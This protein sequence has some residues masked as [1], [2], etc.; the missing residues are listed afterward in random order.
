MTDSAY[1]M[2]SGAMTRRHRA[3]DDPGFG[4][5]ALAE[6]LNLPGAWYDAGLGVAWFDLPDG[7]HVGISH[8]LGIEGAF[9]AVLYR[10]GEDSIPNG[11]ILAAIAN[12]ADS[13]T[14]PRIF[15]DVLRR[16]LTSDFLAVANSQGM[17]A[18]Y[19]EATQ[20]VAIP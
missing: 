16:V 8:G 12:Y 10:A 13:E 2:T 4:F 1:P 15:A 3:E 9:E 18:D 20:I 6:S 11:D 17:L 7:R 14:L 19:Y 5:L